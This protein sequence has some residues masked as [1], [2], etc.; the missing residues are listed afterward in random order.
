MTWWTARTAR[1][2]RGTSMTEY[3]LILTGVAMVMVALVG[4]FNETAAAMWAQ[5][6]ALM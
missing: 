5:T 1:V 2:E 6:V 3:A 4:I